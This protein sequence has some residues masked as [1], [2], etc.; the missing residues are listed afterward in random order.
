MT[1]IF[2]YIKTPKDTTGLNNSIITRRKKCFLVCLNSFSPANEIVIKL[3]PWGWQNG[4]S[5][6]YMRWLKS[7]C[8]RLG[9]KRTWGRDVS[10]FNE[11]KNFFSSTSSKLT[12]SKDWNVKILGIWERM[13]QWRGR[14]AHF[15]ITSSPWVWLGDCSQRRTSICSYCFVWG[16]SLLPLPTH[17]GNYSV[18]FKY[19]LLLFC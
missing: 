17:N 13:E 14:I 8:I 16:L 18:Y 3:K 9:C 19:L 15:W 12:Y 7:P 11:E 10:T 1:S 4:R 2:H 6:H 5:K